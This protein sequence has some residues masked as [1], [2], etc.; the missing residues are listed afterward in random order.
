MKIYTKTGDSGETSLYGGKRVPKNNPVIVL[1]GNIDELNSVFGILVSSLPQELENL[2][3]ILKLRQKEL[4][5]A[6]SMVASLQSSIK[7]N[8]FKKISLRELTELEEQIDTW[9]DEL[10][11]LK[12]F[13]LPGGKLYGAYAHLARAVCRRVERSLVRLQDKQAID[14]LLLAYFNRL[15]DWLFVLARKINN[16]NDVIWTND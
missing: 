12:N 6:G 5:T 1:L 11:E 10:P 15:A 3:E 14:P 2:S 13:I 8:H 7:S 9:Q 4:F 16:G